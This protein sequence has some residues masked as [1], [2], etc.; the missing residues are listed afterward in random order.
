M[1]ASTLLRI[2]TAPKYIM[3]KAALLITP[4]SI[5]LLSLTLPTTL[6]SK[7]P[8]NRNVVKGINRTS[9]FNHPYCMMG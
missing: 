6:A 8:T 7:D 9:T 3:A 4:L 5:I 2:L 1:K